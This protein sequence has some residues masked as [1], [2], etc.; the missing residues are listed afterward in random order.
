MYVEGRVLGTDGNPIAGATIDTWE[1][2]ENGLYD[3]QVRH[4]YTSFPT[5]PDASLSH[6]TRSAMDQIVEVNSC[7][8]TMGR[9]PSGPSCM[10][11]HLNALPLIS[12]RSPLQTRA[13]PH[14]QRRPRREATRTAGTTRLQTRASAY[15][16]RGTHAPT[17]YKLLSPT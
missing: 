13:L 14:P 12:D 1:T 16:G 8:A 5:P 17:P 10:S 3:T 4:L 2:D 11:P 15:D 6:S 7:Q 9:M